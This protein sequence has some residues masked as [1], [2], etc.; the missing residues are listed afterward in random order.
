[1]RTSE[2]KE[3]YQKSDSSAA[4]KIEVP[5]TN[6]RRNRSELQIRRTSAHFP[7][8]VLDLSTHL[9][10][11]S[12]SHGLAVR[13]GVAAPIGI[14]KAVSKNYRLSLLCGAVRGRLRHPHRRTR[15]D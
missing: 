4:F 6:S 14:A 8:F 15:R 2:S 5:T 10:R 12:E 3:L 7:K 13:I 1:M 9:S 11:T